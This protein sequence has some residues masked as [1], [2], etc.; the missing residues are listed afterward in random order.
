MRH[1][2]DFP[3]CDANSSKM[4]IYRLTARPRHD[5]YFSTTLV[6]QMAEAYRFGERLPLL[7]SE[8]HPWTFRRGCRIWALSAYV[9]A[10][11]DNEIDWDSLPK[12]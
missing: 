12:P 2:P 9:P 1:I 3:I 11:R 8:D 10:F 7:G 6:A 4:A 5:A